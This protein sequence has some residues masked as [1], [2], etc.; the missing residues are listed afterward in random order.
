MKTSNRWYLAIVTI[1]LIACWIMGMIK[2]EIL[3]RNATLWFT[4]MIFLL[5][6]LVWFQVDNSELKERG[7]EVIL[8]KK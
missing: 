8:N 4:M 2:H 3:P 5:I 6:M 1:V 7:L